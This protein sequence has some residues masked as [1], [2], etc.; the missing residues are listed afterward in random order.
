M[1][2]RTHSAWFLGLIAV[3]AA[4]AVVVWFTDLRPRLPAAERGRRLAERTGCFGC[5]G[6]G[7]T[8]GVPNAGRTD[9]DVPGFGGEVMMFAE[10]P[11]QIR[12]WITHGVTAAKAGSASWKEQ[13]DRGVLVMPAFGDRLTAEEIDDLTAMVMAMTG[14]P[15]P[16]DSL[17]AAGRARARELGCFGCHGPGGRFARPNPGSLKGYVPPWDGE[18]FEDLVRDRADFDQWVEGGIAERL[19]GNLLARHFLD[20]AALRMPAFR[21]H[22]RSGDL[23]ALWAYVRWLHTDAAAL[24]GAR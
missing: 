4:A 13:R 20:R 19:A 3:L 2:L 12:E 21:D 22:L 7:G 10:G 1:S 17:A 14:W 18:D 8:G 11:G 15:A 9:G 6:P 16:G 5:H 24:P 23:D